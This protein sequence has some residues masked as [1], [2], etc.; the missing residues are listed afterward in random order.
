MTKYGLRAQ[1][2]AF[3]IL[4]TVIIGGILAGYFSFHRY[5][6]ANEF[7]IDRAINIAEPLAI[8]SEYGMQDETRTILR[9][10]VSAT[11][12][13]NSPMIKS[14]AIFTAENELFV[15]SNYHRDSQQLR[16]D[17]NQPIPDLPKLKI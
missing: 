17:E 15:I 6:Q 8:I 11:H 13:Q 10:L 4:P 14:V 9:R 16:L 7:L 12:R 5:Q 3:T 1:V 2:I